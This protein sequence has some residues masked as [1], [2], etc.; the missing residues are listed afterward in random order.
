MADVKISNLPA[1]TTPLDYTETVPVVQGGF[2]KRTT[3][4]DLR[5]GLS[6]DFLGLSDTPPAY[7]SQTLKLLRVNAEET[8]VD[9]VDPNSAL[10]GEANSIPYFSAA[11]VL[12][13]DDAQMTYDGTTLSLLK[14]QLK[15]PATRNESADANTLD[16]CERGTW[17]PTIASTVGAITSY[18]IQSAI[19]RKLGDMVFATVTFTITNNGTGSGYITI[20]LPF[21][22]VE[23]TTGLMIN[24]STGVPG[25]VTVA[26]GGALGYCVQD[27]NTD[28]AVTGNPL[29]C[30]FAYVE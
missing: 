10:V 27:N 15:F 5:A 4:A 19:Y 17:T 3:L 30:S 28:P 29:N 1:A 8:A 9:F 18:T 16:D 24:V 14:G 20:T 2:T 11:N 12:T 23:R 13:G 6:G 7:T 22:S 21:T 26:G 25:L